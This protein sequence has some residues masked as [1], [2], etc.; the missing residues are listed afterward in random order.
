MNFFD[1]AQQEVAEAEERRSKERT[2]Q[3]MTKQELIKLLKE[4]LRIEVRSE[5]RNNYLSGR[6]QRVRV[7]LFLGD[8]LIAEDSADLGTG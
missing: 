8:E 4:Q 6:C 2:R 5:D 1:E 7:M 3:D